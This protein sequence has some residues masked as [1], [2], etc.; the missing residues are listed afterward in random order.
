[1]ISDHSNLYLLWSR[2]LGTC[3]D[4]SSTFVSLDFLGEAARSSRVIDLRSERHDLTILSGVD[5]SQK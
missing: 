2:T 3:C 1:M 5:D 4:K